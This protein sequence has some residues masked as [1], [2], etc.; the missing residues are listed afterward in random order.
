MRLEA[1]ISRLRNE[2]EQHIKAQHDAYLTA[3]QHHKAEIASLM[4]KF[5]GQNAE[6][7]DDSQTRGYE[8]AFAA[9]D[10]VLAS[11]QTAHTAALKE[12]TDIICKLQSQLD[13]HTGLKVLLRQNVKDLDDRSRMQR[14]Q[15]IDEVR[16]AMKEW[17]EAH[18]VQLKKLTSERKALQNEYEAQRVISQQYQ[19]E[20]NS[21]PAIKGDESYLPKLKSIEIV[22]A[23]A[24]MT[25]L[26]TREELVRVLAQLAHREEEAKQAKK[27]AEI[28]RKDAEVARLEA[29]VTIATKDAEMA[30]L[31]S[32]LLA[33][34]KDLELAAAL[35]K[36]SESTTLV[37]RNVSQSL[38]EAV[39]SLEICCRSFETQ[40]VEM[41]GTVSYNPRHSS[42]SDLENPN[43]SRRELEI[44]QN[45]MEKSIEALAAQLGDVRAEQEAW[46][47]ERTDILVQRERL[48][49]KFEELT[50]K[51]EETERKHA[52]LAMAEKKSSETLG[53]LR[54]ENERLREELAKLELASPAKSLGA[55]KDVNANQIGKQQ[56]S[57]AIERKLDILTG[58]MQD[59][60][61]GSTTTSTSDTNFG[62]SEGLATS[63]VEK[64]LR[65]MLGDL[66]M[67]LSREWSKKMHRQE[68]N[69]VHS[70]QAGLQ[71]LVQ[72][73]IG[74]DLRRVLNSSGNVFN[75]LT[76]VRYILDQILSSQ[77]QSVNRSWNRR[78]FD[79]S[80]F[81]NNV[82][83]STDTTER[84]SDG[85]DLRYLI[86]RA[87]IFSTSTRV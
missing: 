55:S 86:L 67:S 7:G 38:S 50:L 35:S 45:F 46:H 69:I 73:Q 20:H 32:R 6:K 13:E 11:L 4:R 23:R 33:A 1:E 54:H 64:S 87:R 70:V 31:E 34:Q 77:R 44:S 74:E 9:K 65:K 8:L 79:D 39:N 66:K 18:D 36:R 48:E 53:R 78:L 28:A 40:I 5:Q 17:N 43:D 14:E 60:S 85:T 3:V 29:E 82:N 49:A 47:A 10:E 80:R 81:T 51:L 25:A 57:A 58:L 71:D 84:E 22:R 83:E 12:K 24:E 52:A 42:S 61:I 68:E 30:R 26:Q 2:K 72:E 37:P 15:L 62:G 75:S 27:E 59:L 76:N 63:A 56:G 19:A 21:S 41:R 16:D